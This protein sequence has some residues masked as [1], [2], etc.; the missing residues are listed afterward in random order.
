MDILK[1][2]LTLSRDLLLVLDRSGNCLEMG[3]HLLRLIE[4]EGATAADVEDLI[5][6]AFPSP[7][8]RLPIILPFEQLGIFASPF[9]ILHWDSEKLVLIAENLTPVSGM[10][11]EDNRREKMETLHREKDRRI[12]ALLDESSDPIFSFREDGTYLYVNNIFAKTLGY[13]KEDIIHKKLWDIFPEDE[14]NRRYAMVKKAFSTGKTDNIEVKIPLASGD[15]YFLTTVKPIKGDDDKV[16]FVICI[17]KDITELRKTQ[18]QLKTLRGILP[19][20]SHCKNIRNDKG[21]WLQLEEYIAINSE[22]EFSHGICPS[23]AQEHYSEYYK[24]NR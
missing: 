22:A 6:Q 1:N 9:S 15:K 10:A 5:R 4:K 24:K 17:S 12:H 18:D 19:I 21:A 23:C 13:A 11:A 3:C 8:F 2:L 14:A 16:L 7:D 20:C